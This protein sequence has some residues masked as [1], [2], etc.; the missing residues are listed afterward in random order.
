MG[1]YLVSHVSTTKWV[2]GES[3]HEVFMLFEYINHKKDSF[4]VH[5]RQ[6]DFFQKILIMVV[7]V[8]S[9]FRKWRFIQMKA[10][11]HL[12][13]KDNKLIENRPDNYIEVA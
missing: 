13:T 4:W 5:L 1:Y 7:R 3:I 11:F 12:E 9:I 8:M 2:L 10:I 6:I